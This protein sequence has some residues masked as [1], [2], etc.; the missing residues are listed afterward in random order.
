ME[1]SWRYRV[2]V[3]IST[4]GVE[5]WSCPAEGEGVSMA[6]VLNESDELV[7]ALRLRYP[8]PKE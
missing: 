2:K 6:E 8:A 3:E 4:Q 7:A 5:T 1:T